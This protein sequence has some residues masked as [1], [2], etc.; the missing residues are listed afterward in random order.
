M[1]QVGTHALEM[2][3]VKS[4]NMEAIGYNKDIGVLCVQFKGGGRYLYFGVP[5]NKF[6]GMQNAESVG[7]YLTSEIKPLY[8]TMRVPDLFVPKTDVQATV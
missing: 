5:E 4:S 8:P 3:G 1:S 2:S 6:T 7:K